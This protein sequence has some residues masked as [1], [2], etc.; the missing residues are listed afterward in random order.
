MF[1]SFDE[2]IRFN[3][4]RFQVA[5]QAVVRAVSGV[6]LAAA[7]FQAVYSLLFAIE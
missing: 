2:L 1:K 6:V 5:R 3:Q 4:T 7:G